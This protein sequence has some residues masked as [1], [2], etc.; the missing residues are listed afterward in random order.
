M[1]DLQLLDI[2][3]C[4]QDQSKLKP[5]NDQLVKQINR[6]IDG[7]QVVTVAGHQL[8]KH[9]EGGLIR[10]SGDL[11]YPIFDQIPVMLPD[12]AIDLKNFQN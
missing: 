3:R 6:A 12:E 10:E 11:M 2:L 4:P 8:E 9:L 5:A 7:K 1:I